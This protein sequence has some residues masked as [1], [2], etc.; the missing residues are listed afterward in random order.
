MRLANCPLS[1][2]SAQL[3]PRVQCAAYSAHTAYNTLGV[4]PPASTHAV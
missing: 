1:A 4:Y 2:K 3:P